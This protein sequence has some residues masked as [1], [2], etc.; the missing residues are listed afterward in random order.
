M[1]KQAETTDDIWTVYILRCK[2]G[3]FYTGITKDI[4]RRCRQHNA[5]IASRYTRSRLP[6]EVV[7][8]ELQIGRGVAIKRELA[9]KALSRKQKE[10]LI[11]VE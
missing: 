4:T 8:Q 6:V 5:G 10:E 3:T 9:V 7:Y 11:L 1:T 2:D